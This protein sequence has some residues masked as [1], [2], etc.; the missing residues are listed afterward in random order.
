LS[1]FP[2][3][4]TLL[5]VL[6]SGETK[7]NWLR[8]VT[9]NSPVVG[10]RVMSITCPRFFFGAK[11]PIS[12]N[13]ESGGGEEKGKREDGEK[14][15]HE[16]SSGGRSSD[17]ITTGLDLEEGEGG[18]RRKEEGRRRRKEEE[19]GGSRKGGRRK[20]EGGGRRESTEFRELMS[21]NRALHPNNSHIMA[22]VTIELDFESLSSRNNN[23][24]PQIFGSQNLGSSEK[25]DV[26]SGSG[27]EEP[28]VR[29]KCLEKSF[30]GTI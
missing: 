5:L 13:L 19:E 9:M 14:G 8:E 21:H 28:R 29:K 25:S 23:S 20:E 1:S 30:L 16:D 22:Q 24:L 26:E 17:Q 2:V 4:K 10:D 15:D 27:S 12:E 11:I 3:L 6:K 7:R 18:R